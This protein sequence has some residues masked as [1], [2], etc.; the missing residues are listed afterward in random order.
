[1]RELKNNYTTA[2]EDNK[3]IMLNV[4]SAPSIYYFPVMIKS[5]GNAK[6]L[7]KLILFDINFLPDSKL[8]WKNAWWQILWSHTKQAQIITEIIKK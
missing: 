6:R 4:F 7:I 1:M 2:E 8:L 5:R 3:G